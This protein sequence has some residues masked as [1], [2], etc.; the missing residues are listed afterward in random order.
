MGSTSTPLRYAALDRALGLGL[1]PDAVLRAG[2]RLAIRQVLRRERAGGVEAEQRRLTELVARKSTGPIAV[3]TDTANEQHYALPPEFFGL[4]L[5]KRRK[6]SGCLWPQGTATIEVAEEAMLELTCERARIFDGAK[7]LD[8][9]CGWGALTLWIAERYPRCEVTAVS[10][11]AP[12][13]EWIEAEAER[14]GLTDRVEVI[15]ADVNDLELD[16]THGGRGFDRVCSVEMFEHLNNWK[17]MLRRVAGWLAPDGLVFIHVFTHRDIAYLYEGTWAAERFFTAGVMPSHDLFLHFQ[18][19][20][21]LRERWA[22]SGSHYSHTLAAWLKRLD[23]H[24]EDALAILERVHGDRG[25]A[26]VA[27]GNWRLFLLSTTEI[28]GWRGGRE[29]M[30][31]HYLF[32]PRG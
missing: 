17:E 14:R 30:V 10:N 18:D 9:G 22:V 3:A 12:Q 6:Y 13:R 4:F 23:E 7:V 26:K 11:S 25:K 20:L 21:R 16:P 1:P 32:E 15:T 24:A 31:S 8:L 5:G 2:S 19:D 29:W 27:L 28:W